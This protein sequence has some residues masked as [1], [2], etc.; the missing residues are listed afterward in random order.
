MPNIPPARS[1]PPS[2]IM[3]PSPTEPTMPATPLSAEESSDVL[4]DIPVASSIWTTKEKAILKHHIQ[5]YRTSPKKLKA[6]YIVEH[7]IP[8]IK[9]LWDGRYSKKNMA[10]DSVVK[11]EWAKKKKVRCHSVDVRQMSHDPDICSQSSTGS[12]TMQLRNGR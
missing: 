7:V 1:V 8:K 6:A 11:S 12:Q 10:R 2:P 4:E 5:G 9:A 3:P